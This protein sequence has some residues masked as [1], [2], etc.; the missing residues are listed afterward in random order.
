MRD[1]VIK[2]HRDGWSDKTVDQW[3]SSLATYVYP[4]I[5]DDMRVD[6]MDT[7]MVM[8][9]LSPHWATKTETMSRVRRRI[10][11]VL[12][13]AK[14]HGYR[15]GENPARWR[16]HLDHLLPAHMKVART[17]HHEA[18]PYAKVASFLTGLRRRGGAAARAL[19]FCILTATRSGEVL[20]AE[21]SDVDRDQRMWTIPARQDE[22]QARAPGPAE[23]SGNGDHRGDGSARPL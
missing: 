3:D 6:A 20:N 5:G 10:E 22:V 15:D 19:E 12:D 1:G 11:A 21:W 23:R 8:R 7:A 4:V 13:A 2:A 9:V 14:V 18:M 17:E 16:G